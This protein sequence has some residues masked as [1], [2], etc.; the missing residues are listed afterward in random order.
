MLH[1]MNEVGALIDNTV[2]IPTVPTTLNEI[3]RIINDPDGSAVEAADVVAKD[4]AIA[5]K[6]L[7]L[8]NSS[9]YSLRVEVSDVKHAVSILGLR[10]L[11][12]LVVQA[13][14]LEQFKVS[15][16]DS[17]AFN[18]EWLWDH[19]V[20]TATA[21]RHLAKEMKL[22]GVDVESAYTAGLL[23]D[24][25]KILLLQDPSE[26]FLDAVEKSRASGIS[27]HLCEQEIYG[28]HHGHA[29]ALLALR[30]K[31]SQLLAQ[32]IES[33]HDPL[34]EEEEHVKFGCML[35]T[36]NGLAHAAATGDGG[37]VGDKLEDKVVGTL[38]L[39]PARIPELIEMVKQAELIG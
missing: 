3:N 2:S 14:I 19:S 24:V 23:H 28:F 11:R 26:R 30:W 20:K 10:I 36:A 21:A 29:G 18:P 15:Q 27:L 6:V 9:L 39:D 37:Y 17:T 16:G 25:G 12:N 38:G 7:R 13:T 5:T 32:V 31:L 35:H 4:P 33:H 22:P 8:A 34:S 1:T